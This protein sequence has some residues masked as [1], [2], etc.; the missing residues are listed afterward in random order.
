M[1]DLEK[2]QEEMAKQYR[3]EEEKI[4]KEIEEI[5]GSEDTEFSVIRQQNK[6]I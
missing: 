4:K 3:M 1:R 5:F 2:E 6:R